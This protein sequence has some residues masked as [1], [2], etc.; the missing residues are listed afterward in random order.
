MA[1]SQREIELS[2]IR[3]QRWRAR[4]AAAG[5]TTRTPEQLARAVEQKRVARQLASPRAVIDPEDFGHP[6]SDARLGL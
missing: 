3:R 6:E 5:L 1:T 4:R 2:R